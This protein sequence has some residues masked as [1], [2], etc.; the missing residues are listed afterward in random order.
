MEYLAEL[1]EGHCYAR[2]D[3]S[4]EINAVRDVVV[5]YDQDL[6][7]GSYCQALDPWICSMKI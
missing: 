2:N 3:H 7:S 5:L 4:N 1:R 6:P